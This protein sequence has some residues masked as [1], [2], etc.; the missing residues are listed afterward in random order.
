MKYAHVRQYVVDA[1]WAILPGKLAVIQAMLEARSE[2]IGA[3]AEELAAFTGGRPPGPSQEGMVAVLPLRG[4]IAHR[5]GMMEES[6][7]GTSTE[8][9]ARMYRQVMADPN[10]SAVVLDV[11]S[12]GGAVPGLHELAT[13][14]L[15]LRGTKK[16]IAV[17]NS[18]MA[19]AAYWLASAAADE[20][21]CI[22]SGQ[23]GSIGVASIYLDDS[24]KRETEGVTAEVFT[25][26]ANKADVL[27]LGPLSPEAKAR[28]QARVDEAGQWFRGDVAKG[29]GVSVADVRS[30]FGEGVVFGAKGAKAAGLIDRIDTMDSTLARLTGKARVGGMRAEGEMPELVAVIPTEPIEQVSTPDADKELRARRFRL[31]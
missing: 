19:S 18:T 7:G 30:R 16:V 22:P 13:E 8:S 11:D 29:R 1:L 2:G 4:V 28:I 14:M 15:A 9:F 25:S 20:I 12:P 10:I 24:K 17:A 3:T 26:G 5:A 23:V 6:S 21:V 27:G 31:L